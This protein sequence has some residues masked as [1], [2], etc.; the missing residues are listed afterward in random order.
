MFSTL[1]LFLFFIW[2]CRKLFD[3]VEVYVMHTSVLVSLWRVE[4]LK[5]LD[6]SPA[7]PYLGLKDRL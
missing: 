4:Q 5:E 1:Q 7:V 6:S 2:Y 3:L